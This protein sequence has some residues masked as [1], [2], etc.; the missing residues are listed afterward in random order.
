MPRRPLRETPGAALLASLGPPKPKRNRNTPSAAKAQLER[1][2]DELIDVIEKKTRPGEPRHLVALYAKCHEA[3]YGVFPEELRQ[4]K[5]W[6]AACGSARRTIADHFAGDFAEAVAFMRWD[7]RR[8]QK[9]TAR[10]REQ[11]LEQ[12]FRIKWRQ[13]FVFRDRITDYRAAT[14]EQRRG[15]R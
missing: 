7:W 2:R 5:E 6:L 9:S 14:V 11:G 1:A 13:Q 3:V 4:P 12:T 8:E 10:K 15:A